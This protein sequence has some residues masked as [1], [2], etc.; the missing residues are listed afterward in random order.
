MEHLNSLQKVLVLSP[1]DAV[2]SSAVADLTHSKTLITL[3]FKN[4]SKQL[5]PKLMCCAVGV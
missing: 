3:T 1:R 4:L 5:Q 2:R